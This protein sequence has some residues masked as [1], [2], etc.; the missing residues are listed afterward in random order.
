MVLAASPESH[1]RF[2]ISP[3]FSVKSSSGPINL[4]PSQQPFVAE[5]KSRL[6]D[7]AY[8]LETSSCPC[9]EASGVVISE[10]DR[11]GLPLTF[12]LCTVCG[13]IRIDPYWDTSGLEDFYTRF[14]QQM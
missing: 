10:V 13:T 6:Q 5:V 8:K 9:G 11:Y 1:P 7:G 12:V 2:L 3:R 14:Y 4:K